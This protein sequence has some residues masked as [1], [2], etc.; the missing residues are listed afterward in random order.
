MLAAC[1][2][3]PPP[4]P[5]QDEPKKTTPVP[6]D[7][8]FND[9]IP[10]TGPGGGLAVR[11]DGG[12]LEGGLAASDGGDVAPEADAHRV[13]LVEPGA[14][15]RA[16][17][18]YAFVANRADK[19]VLTIR[20]SVSVQG[21]RQD[22]P[23]LAMTVELTPKEVKPKATRFDMK[24]VKVELADQD[25]LPP[26]LVQQAAKE[27][28]GFSGLT[29]TFEVSP[30][31]EVGELSMSGTDKM[32]RQ[33]AEELLQALQQ[34]VELI[35]APLPDAPIG[36]GAK[37][38]Q[39]ES[40]AEG[41][42]KQTGKRTLE[43]KDLGADGNATIVTTIERKLG[44][45]PVPDPRARGATMEVDAKGTYTYALR[46]DRIASKVSGELLQTTK[47]EAPAGDKGEKR[48]MTQEAK[49]KH[50]METPSK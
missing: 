6:S 7:M 48:A 36:V 45:R 5:I 22:Q 10:Q 2:K 12:L 32:A 40:I 18:K 16:V 14:E 50:V 37:W 35:V 46:F 41:P 26:Q 23:P 19:R 3:D 27:L 9:F 4:K 1:N 24:V 15:P 17:R 11:V 33:G 43:L 39:D 28:G 29:A 8:V 30:R 47:V 34:F 38:E 25:K 44:K 49:I 31:G 21:Q 13:K 20:Q 42:L